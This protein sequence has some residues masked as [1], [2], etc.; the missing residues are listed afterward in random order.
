MVG[1][2]WEKGLCELLVVFASVFKIK[3]GMEHFSLRWL[4]SEGSTGLQ[5]DSALEY[6]KSD[7]HKATFQMHLR[8]SE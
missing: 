2:E 7:A 1:I 8:V 3:C 6:V 5:H 4:S